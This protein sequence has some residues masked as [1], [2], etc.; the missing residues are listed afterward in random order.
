MKVIAEAAGSEGF[1]ETSEERL[2]IQ[3]FR[4]FQRSFPLPDVEA[5]II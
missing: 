2:E 1:S 4:L 3:I 5:E